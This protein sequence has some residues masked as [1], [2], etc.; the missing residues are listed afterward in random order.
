VKT[1]CPSCQTIFRV[2]S[3]Q[4]RA[5]AGKVRCG[6]CR[7]VFNAIDGLL[8]DDAP[9]TPIPRSGGGSDFCGAARMPAAVAAW[10]SNLA[11]AH[12]SPRPKS[13]PPA[14]LDLPTGFRAG[15]CAASR[16][17]AIESAPSALLNQ[18]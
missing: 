2:T 18:A 5:R 14:E 15:R 8:D 13:W 16:Q 3:E 9:P 4:I 10:L 12:P 6:Q 17:V 11:G 7:T 1:C